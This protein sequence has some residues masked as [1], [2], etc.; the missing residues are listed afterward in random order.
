M[1]TVRRRLQLMPRLTAAL[2]VMVLSLGG[3]LGLSGC[4]VISAANPT[5]KSYTAVVTATDVTTGARSSMNVTL[6][7]Q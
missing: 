4:G 6:I 3:L 5:A 2:T 1:K 7:V